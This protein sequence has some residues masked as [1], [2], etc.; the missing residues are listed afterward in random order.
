MSRGVKEILRIEDAKKEEQEYAKNKFPKMIEIIDLEVRNRFTKAASISTIKYICS[1]NHHRSQD[2][3]INK[4]IVSNKYPRCSKIESCNHIVKCRETAVFCE[5][6]RIK[7]K[8]KLQQYKPDEISEEEIEHMI[9][10]IRL[11]L[12][13][14]DKFFYETNQ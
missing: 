8:Q 5:E 13:S 9:S 1:F 7:L 4:D 3:T 2:A 10:D 12:T 11:F 14:G 6:F